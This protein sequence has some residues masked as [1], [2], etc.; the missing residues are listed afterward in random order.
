M[1]IKVPSNHTR[2]G[3]W[4]NSKM[5]VGERS[6][7]N[8]SILYN[9]INCHAR[10]SHKHRR[11][12]MLGFINSVCY[13][14]SINSTIGWVSLMKGIHR[15]RC[16]RDPGKLYNNFCNS[17]LTRD[18]TAEPVSR[19][20]I[21]RHARGQGNI[22]F[23]CSAGHEQD[24]RPYPV[25]HTLLYVMTIHTYSTYLT[26]DQPPPSNLVVYSTINTVQC[27]RNNDIIS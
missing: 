7:I 21:L 14:T 20:Q 1:S 19:D 3:A 25:D 16:R 13:M 8:S 10:I 24:W 22:H 11:H 2:L 17:R 6:T 5:S 15:Y 23:P 4:V 18:G 12:G 26:K 9:T 27:H